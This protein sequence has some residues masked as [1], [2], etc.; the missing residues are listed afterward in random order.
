MQNGVSS[1]VYEGKRQVKK[2]EQ[3]RG[4]RR[5]KK[6]GGGE[7]RRK[8][9]RTRDSPNPGRSGL[10]HFEDGFSKVLREWIPGFEGRKEV[11][12]FKHSLRKILLL[13]QKLR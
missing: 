6:E 10:S 3:G 5:G 11:M 12:K 13:V 1:N 9:K 8:K 4:E 7:K 2:R